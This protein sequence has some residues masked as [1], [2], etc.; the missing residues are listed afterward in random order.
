MHFAVS[1]LPFHLCHHQ[2]G[3]KL[4]LV[5]WHKV[6]QIHTANL[7]TGL[8]VMLYMVSHGNR[9]ISFVSLSWWLG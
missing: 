9:M 5:K 8:K 4:Y 6:L 7:V 3:E 2:C 1:L